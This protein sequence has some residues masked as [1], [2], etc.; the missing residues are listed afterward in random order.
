MQILIY[1]CLFLIY[2]GYLGAVMF[3]YGVDMG[4]LSDEAGRYI[5]GIRARL[6]LSAS[7]SAMFLCVF[8]GCLVECLMVVFFFVFGT[9]SLCCVSM[10]YRD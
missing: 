3:A 4:Y 9:Y 7:E 1:M 8:C 6:N 2:V 10:S 5:S